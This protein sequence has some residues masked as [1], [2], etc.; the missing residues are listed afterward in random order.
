MLINFSLCRFQFYFRL[1]GASAKLSW[2]AGQTL[3]IQTPIDNNYI[4][5]SNYWISISRKLY[6][7]LDWLGV[8]GR[9]QNLS[10]FFPLKNK[11]NSLK[12]CTVYTPLQRGN[13]YIYTISIQVFICNFVKSNVKWMIYIPSIDIRD[14][15]IR[16]M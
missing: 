14:K 12:Y 16:N 5:V 4:G 8:L 11:W 15:D 6:I 2:S 7:R 3:Q 10:I 9:A 13:I 1:R